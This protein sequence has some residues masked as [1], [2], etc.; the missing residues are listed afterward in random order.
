[1]AKEPVA[2]FSSEH[3]NLLISRDKMKITQM[4]GGEEQ[5]IYTNPPSYS[6]KPDGNLTVYSKE[7]A[8]E[9]RE[10][11]LFEKKF[12]EVPLPVRRVAD[13][14]KPKQ[15]EAEASEEPE[16]KDTIVEGVDS[17]NS[18]MTYLKNEF[19]FEHK[20]VN[21]KEKIFEKA[22]EFHLVFPNYTREE[23]LDEES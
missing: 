5:T 7:E 12:I 4:V 13:K 15:P 2:K 16:V 3:S 9:L 18:A 10:H 22:A 21:T 6:F 17:Y 23:N 8:E 20:D 1:M 19:G 14:E 11:R